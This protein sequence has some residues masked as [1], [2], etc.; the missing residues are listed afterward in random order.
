[1]YYSNH[2][3]RQQHMNQS[4]H[5]RP[6]G[7]LECIVSDTTIYVRQMSAAQD[8]ESQ[9]DIK[10]CNSIQNVCFGRITI[11]NVNLSISDGT[12][13]DLLEVRIEKGCGI[14]EEMLND[15]LT[16]GD[17]SIERQCWTSSIQQMR[18]N[19]ST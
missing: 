12:Q 7:L 5:R 13:M 8:V 18:Q 15:T 10:F 19:L 1:M 6:D 14:K 16:D 17:F 11:A 4:Y 3:Y 9:E 2:N